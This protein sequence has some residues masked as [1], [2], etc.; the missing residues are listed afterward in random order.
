MDSNYKCILDEYKVIKLDKTD[1]NF[2][3][4]IN[5]LND[6]DE[7]AISLPLLSGQDI[8]S[9]SKEIKVMKQD[10][11]VKNAMNEIYKYLLGESND[12]DLQFQKEKDKAE[13][14]GKKVGVQIGMKAG[15]KAERIKIA[16]RMLIDDMKIYKVNKYTGLSNRVLKKLKLSLNK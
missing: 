13:K 10:M 2:I 4:F 15:K 9:F 8:D 1:Y 11:S 12:L 5:D 3:S 14:T 16:K 6:F 7:N